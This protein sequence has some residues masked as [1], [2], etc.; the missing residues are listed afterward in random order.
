VLDGGAGADVLAGGAGNDAYF[1]DN[2][3]DQVLEN[4]DE[5]N[6]TVYAS[7]DYRLTANLDNVILQGSG[8]LQAYGNGLVNALYGNSGNDI[9]NGEADADAMYGGGGNDAY[10]STTSTTW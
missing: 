7:I 2:S 6:D 8:D 3:S 5:G 9:L 10:S 4:P 1:V